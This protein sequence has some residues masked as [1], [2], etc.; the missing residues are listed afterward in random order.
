MRRCF[1]LTIS[2]PNLCSCLSF[3][4][5]YAKESGRR[6]DAADNPVGVFVSVPAAVMAASGRLL[7][8]TRSLRVDVP[9]SQ[10]S[11]NNVVPRVVRCIVPKSCIFVV[12]CIRSRR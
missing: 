10:V 5:I 3:T 1:S 9:Y 8:G 7:A 4:Q 12:L 11:N 2:N 6:D